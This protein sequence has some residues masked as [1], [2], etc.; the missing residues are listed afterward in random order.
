MRTLVAT[1]GLSLALTLFVAELG[2]GVALEETFSIHGAPPLSELRIYDLVD[3]KG[4][5]KKFVGWAYLSTEDGSLYE[6]SVK[7]KVKKYFDEYRIKAEKIRGIRKKDQ[8]S[9]KLKLRTNPEVPSVLLVKMKYYEPEYG[10]HKI[11]NTSAIRFGPQAPK[12]VE[13]SGTIDAPDVAADP[14]TP[15]TVYLMDLAF[16][17]IDRDEDGNDSFEFTVDPGEDYQVVVVFS[18]GQALVALAPEMESDRNVTV[19]V[20]SETAANLVVATEGVP[21]TLERKNISGPLADLLADAEE[22]VA[23]L[24]GFYADRDRNR[25]ADRLT[26]AVRFITLDRLNQGSYVDFQDLRP[27]CLRAY[28]GGMDAG[29]RG[30]DDVLSETKTPYNP[31]FVFSRFNQ[32]GEADF[33]MSNL[34]TRRWDLIGSWG[35]LPHGVPG[36]KKIVYVAPVTLSYPET[37]YPGNLGIYVKTLGSREEPERLTPDWM[38]CWAP[39]I[40]PD[41]S[42]IVFSARSVPVYYLGLDGADQLQPN[43]Y[44][45][46][47]M[48]ADGEDLE[49]LTNDT[50]PEA[51][52][53]QIHGNVYATWHPDGDRIVFTHRIFKL[54]GG[55]SELLGED[56]IET[57]RPDGTGRETIL[58]GPSSGYR[59]PNFASWAPDGERLVIECT[60]PGE[61]DAEIMILTQSGGD[62]YARKLTDNAASDLQPSWSYDGRFV[63]FTSNRG[64]EKGTLISDLFPIYVANSYTGEIVAT[65][66]DFTSA[67]WYG[68]PR[69]IA[70][71]VILLALPEVDPDQDGE[72]EIPA[73]QSD[74][75]TS[76]SHKSNSLHRTI[77]PVA[78]SIGMTFSTTSWFPG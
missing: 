24:H 17:E 68:G 51:M 40:S 71:E 12:T 11:T 41:E 28:G 1:V 62:V 26:E 13:L 45:L 55:G 49:L 18:G 6:C 61:T 9:F 57:I 23:R 22:A 31:H 48:D 53:D 67:G 14:G 25:D 47:L 75:R 21:E 15:E 4:K 44:N 73:G 63:I 65:L 10:K 39:A 43:L 76:G 56:R 38:D 37:L 42:K 60:P 33:G 7:K 74:P 19:S 36:G 32:N 50:N 5:G 54:G 35:G 69:F 29:T 8:L 46:A 16:N 52:A 3:T 59:S 2:A 27:E 30:L 20:D 34:D 58:D 72:A 77:L 66:G 64:G 70:V 78:N